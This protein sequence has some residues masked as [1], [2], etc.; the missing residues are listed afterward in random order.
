MG[1]VGP[2]PDPNVGWTR[3]K[4]FVPDWNEF[5]GFRLLFY[6]GGTASRCEVH[7]WFTRYDRSSDL[8][9][10]NRDDNERGWST[11]E[12]TRRYHTPVPVLLTLSVT[13]TVPEAVVDV[14]ATEPAPI[15][16]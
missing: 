8:P 13:P 5:L 10:A 4:P 15:T 2:R 1:H 12:D 3:I 7:L 11:G 14:T 16:D 6:V 9:G